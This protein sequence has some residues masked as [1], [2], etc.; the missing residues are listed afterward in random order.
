MLTK[1]SNLWE[2]NTL[3]S[4]PHSNNGSLRPANP[5]YWHAIY[6]WFLLQ[7]NSRW[8]SASP[9]DICQTGRN[10]SRVLEC[11]TFLTISYVSMMIWPFWWG[12]HAVLCNLLVNN[13]YYA[14]WSPRGINRPKS[15]MRLSSLRIQHSKSL[16]RGNRGKRS[17]RLLF[18]RWEISQF[19]RNFQR[20]SD[21]SLPSEGWTLLLMVKCINLA[22]LT[23][24]WYIASVLVFKICSLPYF[25]FGYPAICPWGE[26]DFSTTCREGLFAKLSRIWITRLPFLMYPLPLV[27]PI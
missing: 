2:N 6:V 15:S 21:H 11:L 1:V 25:M 26:M 5:R 17:F 7:W 27:L 12:S 24:L 8:G 3:V 16:R 19:F 13:S 18:M 4:L 23:F 20:S 22:M 10:R 14:S 9:Q